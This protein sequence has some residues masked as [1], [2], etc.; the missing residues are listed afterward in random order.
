MAFAEEFEKN[1]KLFIGVAVLVVVAIVVIVMSMG[2]GPSRP[3]LKGKPK[4]FY[5][6]DD[7]KTY[8]EDDADKSLGFERDGKPAY[9]VQVYQCGEG[10][11]FVG[12]IQ[13]VEEGARKEA[14]AARA[15]GKKPADV[16]AIWLN[17]VEVKKPGEAKWLPISKGEKVMIVTC[18]DGKTAANIVLP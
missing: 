1:K 17:K 12:Y 14:E 4:L 6:V 15:A 18:P 5:T 9:R 16:E 3:S 10:K 2:G 7:G 8:F 11:P 13:R